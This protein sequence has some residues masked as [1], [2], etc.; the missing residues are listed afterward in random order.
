VELARLDAD[1][2][3]ARLH[4]LADDAEEVAGID[5]FEQGVLVCTKLILTKERLDAARGVLKVQEGRA[6]HPTDAADDPAGDSH[7][8]AAV[9]FEARHHV[10]CQVGAIEARR[11]RIDA[12]R[13]QPVELVEALFVQPIFV[14]IV[15]IGRLRLARRCLGI[16]LC[17]SITPS[18]S[19]WCV[20][21]PRTSGGSRAPVS[22]FVAVAT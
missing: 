11:I 2:A 4:R 5:Q 1:L 22:A 14:L 13:A 18:E 10:R 17:H 16:V 7:R 6:A 3:G 12:S 15:L 21:V 8:L 19:H 20:A 9:A